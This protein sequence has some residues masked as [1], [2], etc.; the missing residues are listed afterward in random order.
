MEKSRL[1]E[2]FIKFRDSGDTPKNVGVSARRAYKRLKKLAP[3]S[4]GRRDI[5]D[6]FYLIDEAFAEVKRGG[7]LGRE[8]LQYCRYLLSFMTPE[9]VEGDI[10]A[11]FEVFADLPLFESEA[12]WV[13]GGLLYSAIGELSTNEKFDINVLRALLSLDFTPFL[14]GYNKSEQI[15][16]KDSVY[17]RCDKETRALYRKKIE[18]YAHR[19]AIGFGEACTRLVEE[20]TAR[21]CHIGE[22]LEFGKTGERWLFLGVLVFL[23]L[24]YLVRIILWQSVGEGVGSL[25]LVLS[26]VPLWQGSMEIMGIFVSRFKKPEI[27]PR[28]DMW[29]I[30]EEYATLSVI[31]S[32]ASSK[33][34]V[35]KLF[36]H[37]ELLSL[38]TQ[39][40]GRDEYAFWGVLLDLPES[41]SERGEHDDEILGRAVE[42]TD[43]LNKRYGDKFVFFTRERRYDSEKKKYVPHERKR[44]A[45]VEL[46]KLLKTGESTV[47]TKRGCTPSVK[48]VVVLDSDTD[49]E[50]GALNKMVGTAAHPM[51][52]PRLSKRGGATVVTQGFGVLQPAIITNMASSKKSRFASLLSGVGGIDFYH[53]SI[54]NLNNALFGEGIFC[55]KGIFDID[56]YYKA[57]CDTLPDN[58]ILSHDIL[59]GT[60][61]RCGYLPDIR[62]FDSVPSNVIAYYQRAHRW[63]RGDVQLMKFLPRKVDSFNG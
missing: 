52:A 38:K 48:Y 43:A 30:P 32:L 40:R 54:F 3:A 57:L 51:N 35:E 10:S 31:A 12:Y 21:G 61:L 2:I 22:L 28:L 50:L 33:E 20:A 16:R 1:K 36:E 27:L 7:R 42:I 9:S 13:R 59:E 19:R 24:L 63:A 56:A 62:F 45:S 25:V 34:E 39:R 6:N 41:D 29:K 4:A 60:R 18:A 53:S 46:V 11:F 55:G 37:L 58:I 8:E 14:L 23:S 49:M 15:L 17:A 47:C 5:S 44:G 26:L